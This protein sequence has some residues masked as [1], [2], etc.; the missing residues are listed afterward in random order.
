M[1]S[2]ML[3]SSLFQRL[4]FFCTCDNNKGYGGFCC[5][6]VCVCS[7]SATIG[8]YRITYR[9]TYRVFCIFWVWK[10]TGEFF[11]LPDR[12]LEMKRNM[13]QTNIQPKERG[14]SYD[15]P[16]NDVKKSR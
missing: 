11:L 3:T 10:S 16:Q 13:S 9:I 12:L 4:F 5:E 14:H 8:I 6:G 1:I 15:T 7:K 2:E